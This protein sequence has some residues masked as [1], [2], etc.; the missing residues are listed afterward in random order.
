M[1]LVKPMIFVAAGLL[2]ASCS[3][4]NTIVSLD[5]NRFVNSFA[6]DLFSHTYLWADEVS[7]KVATWNMTGNPVENVAGARMKDSEGNLIDR[8]TTLMPDSKDF[9]S[10]VSSNRLSLGF[11]YAIYLKKSSDSE[12]VLVVLYVSPGG[13]AEQAGLRRGDVIDKVGGSHITR[14]NYRSLLR[15]IDSPLQ[16]CTLTMFKDGREISLSPREFHESPILLQKIFDNGIDKIGYMVFNSFNM[17]ADADLRE[18]GRFFRKNGVKE[19][20]LDLRYNSGGYLMTE[21]MLASMLA[22]KSAVEAEELY[23]VNV[24]NKYINE[25]IGDKSK[26]ESR[27]SFDFE[28]ELEGVKHKFSTADAN[29]GIS[30]L[31]ILTGPR[32]ASASESL[33]CCIRAFLPVEIIGSRTVGK[34]CGGQL[35]KGSDWYE[36]NKLRSRRAYREDA[37]GNWCIYLMTAMWTDKFGKNSAYP[38]G[39]SPDMDLE[40]KPLEMV[41]LGEESESLLS[42]ALRRAG[43]GKTIKPSGECEKSA[44][45]A[46][47][48]NIFYAGEINPRRALRIE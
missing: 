39:I 28:Y 24:F 32:T 44:T 8:W 7:G 40:D 6:R 9:L 46:D 16:T 11:D 20:I 25:A 15:S 29:I 34:F 45:A 36:R 22:P 48:Y 41:P 19:L 10:S 26:R 17:D 5:E 47:T 3:K 21:R 23:S 18:A 38:S 27:L 2:W 14:S 4:D 31:Y 30:K 12:L 33:I 13:P 42:A 35:F 37:V 43:F 1:K